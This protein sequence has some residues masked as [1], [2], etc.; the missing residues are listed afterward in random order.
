M[1]F[2]HNTWYI[3]ILG[4]QRIAERYNQQTLNDFAESYL[5]RHFQVFASTEDF[6]DLTSSELINILWRDELNVE[7]E[8]YLIDF[9]LKWV[10]HDVVE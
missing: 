1:L 7:N 5:L 8:E 3:F 6:L 10:D 4:V 2:H 9:I